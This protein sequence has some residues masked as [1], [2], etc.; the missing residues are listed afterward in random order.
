[1]AKE[2]TYKFPKTMGACADK[3][4]EL[5][6][7]RLEQQKIVDAIE[8]EEKALK[9]HIIEN[10]PKSEATGAAG[11]IARV[12]VISFEVPQVKD[13]EAFWKAFNKKTDT[14]LLQRSVNKAAINERL[15]A[16][17]KVP[18]VEIYKDLKLSITKV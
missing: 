11:K 15:E 4:Y 2:T 7:K 18:G 16:G 17:K 9:K 3:V 5:R 10:L 13:W 6:N 12:S 14:D 8:D 1:M